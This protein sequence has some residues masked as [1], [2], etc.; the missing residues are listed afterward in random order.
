MS[1]ERN[2]QIDSLKFFLIFLVLVG[3]CLDIGL[4]SHYNSALFRF[5]YSFHMP[6]FVILSGIVFRTKN[7]KDL[8]LGGG[9][10]GLFLFNFSAIVW[11]QSACVF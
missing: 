10:F 6:V 5:I 3:H 11:R 1:K 7:L 4:S 2:T 8:L 9:S